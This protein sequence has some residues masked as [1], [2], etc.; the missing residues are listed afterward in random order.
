MRDR[1]LDQ[2]V[3]ICGESGSGKTGKSLQL[4]AIIKCCVLLA[5]AGCHVF[6]YGEIGSGK[7][8]VNTYA[9][10]FYK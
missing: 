1:N 8:L 7:T 9:P 4:V 10:G 5:I 6:I 2:C 3:I